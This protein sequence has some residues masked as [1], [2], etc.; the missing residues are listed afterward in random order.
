MKNILKEKNIVSIILK[1]LSKYGNIPNDGFLCGGAVANTLMKLKWGG[2]YPVNDLDIFVETKNY[3]STNTPN[4]TDRLSMSTSYFHLNASYNHGNMYRIVS[5]DRD[6]MINIV[7]VFRENRDKS[8]NFFYILKGFDLNC[9]QVGID[10][11]SGEL[12]YT[13]EF[14]SF[15]NDKQLK[16]VA[17]YTPSHTAVRLFKKI[18]ELGCYCDVDGQM[19][20]LSQPFNNHSMIRYSRSYTGIFAM[21]FGIKYKEMYDKYSDKLKPY[22]KMVSLF[23]YKKIMWDK[24]WDLIDGEDGKRRNTQHILNWLNPNRNPSQETLDKWASMNGKIW[25]LLPVKFSEPDETFNE[26]IG[27]SF[28]PLTLISVWGMLYGGHKKTLIKKIK[29]VLQKEYLKDLCMV[30]ED[31]YDCDFSEKTLGDLNEY[32]NNNR[33]FANIVYKYGLN[34]QESIDLKKD[35]TTLINKEGVWFSSMIFNLLIT[36]GHPMVKPNIDGIMDL[37]EKEKVKLTKPIIKGIDLSDMKLPSDVDVKELVSEYDLSYAGRRLSNCINNPNQKYKEKIKKGDTKIFVITTP[38]SMSAL[39]INKQVTLDGTTIWKE[40]WTLSYCN[41]V[42]NDYHKH[43]SMYILSYV[44][45]ELLLS[46]ISKTLERLENR[47]DTSLK[48]MDNKQD[49]TTKDNPVSHDEVNLFDL[50]PEIF[51]TPLSDESLP[52]GNVEITTD[53]EVNNE[54]IQTEIISIDDLDNNYTTIT[55][56]DSGLYPF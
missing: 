34:I 14:E 54:N 17:P 26:I 51:P 49:T 28:T 35:I 21:F 9:T 42:C 25:G 3:K 8:K 30:I 46:D 33:E 18:D 16:V 53:N 29:M 12:L 55:T 40:R 43:I 27:G 6:G 32:V 45:K 56:T 5:S 44:Q 38:G 48:I 23:E 36:N 4:R 50:D 10:L 37:F 47:M 41:K 15:L 20:L 11:R 1:E 24:R 52:L 31:F 2:D 7:K 22:F 39:E 19:K 13:K